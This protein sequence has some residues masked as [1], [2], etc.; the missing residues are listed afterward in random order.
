MRPE[1][2]SDQKRTADQKAAGKNISGSSN[3]DRYLTR[4]ALKMSE[5]ETMG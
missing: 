5:K 1:A 3:L 2:A 4:S